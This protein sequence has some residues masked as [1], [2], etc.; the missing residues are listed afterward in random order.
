MHQKVKIV[1]DS[2]QDMP[3]AWQAKWDI[4]MI[5]AFVNFGTE[6]FPDDGVSLPKDEFYRRLAEAKVLPSTAAPPAAIA[7][8]IIAGHLREAEHLLIFTVAHQFS[9][10]YNS[11]RLAAQRVDAARTTVIDTGSVSMGAGWAALAAA[12]LAAQ[13]GDS[14]ACEAIARSTLARGTFYAVIDTL[15]YLR[16]GGR[17][18]GLIAGLGTILQIKPI[19]SV[20][21]GTVETASRVRTMGKGIQTL[22]DLTRASAP[23]ERVAFLHS[24]AQQLG[25]Q[26]HDM[27][28]D[29]LPTGPNDNVMISEVAVAIGTHIGPGCAGV[30]A[31]RKNP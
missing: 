13:G 11:I 12:E 14:A 10:L 15:E 23:L 4:A 1:I 5:P 3:P 29:A 21:N 25:Q 2:G 18:S 8:D 16:R 9:S 7:E 26:L 19:I 31:V 27:L 6:S 17:V 24:N 20:K 28:A 22:I 30:I